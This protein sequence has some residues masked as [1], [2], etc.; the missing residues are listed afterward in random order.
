MASFILVLTLNS[1][2]HA[3][4]EKLTIDD[5][6]ASKLY[7]TNPNDPAIAQWKNSLQRAINDLDGCFD[8]YTVMTCQ[9]LIETVISNCNSHPNTL[10][11]CNDSRLPQ[12]PSLLEKAKLEYRSKIPEYAMSIID[13]C[14]N[15]PITNTTLIT[16][17]SSC[18]GELMSLQ[19]E[20]LITNSTYDY[21]K[22][23]R[24]VE[25]LEQ[26][27]PSKLTVLPSNDNSKELSVTF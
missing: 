2:T 26:H 15:Y 17:S 18:E 12:Y 11:A 5:N 4:H 13:K 9:S 22:D 3:F 16:L 1:Y 6:A 20:C 8:V 25:Y 7:Q 24:F 27:K 14:L 19:G 10:I 23:N 21:C